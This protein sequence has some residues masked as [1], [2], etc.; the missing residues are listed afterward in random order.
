MHGLEVCEITVETRLIEPSNVAMVYASTIGEKQ[1]RRQ[2]TADKSR[3]RAKDRQYLMNARVTD[4][5]RKSY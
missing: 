3:D 1:M 4:T 2:Q 5:G